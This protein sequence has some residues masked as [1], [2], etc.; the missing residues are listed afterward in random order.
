MK[1][2]NIN[3]GLPNYYECVHAELKTG[4]V[5]EVWRASNGEY[6]IW[7]KYGTDQ[8]FYDDD[9]VKWKRYQLEDKTG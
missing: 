3:N 1:W 8:V 6:N 9:I 2:I 5:V 4:K 7:T